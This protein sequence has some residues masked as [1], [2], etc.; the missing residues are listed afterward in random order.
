MVCPH[1][2]AQVVD[3]AKFCSQCGGKLAL[4]CSGCQALVQPG[5]KFCDQCGTAQ[6]T[7]KTP[8]EA[9]RPR[10]PT[11]ALKR[12]TTASLQKPAGDRRVVTVLFTDVSGFTAM[13]EKLDPEEV[14]EIVNNFFNVLV[15]PIY[16]YGGVVDKYIGDAIMA[17]FGAP[18]AHEDDPE[19]AVLAAWE[20]QHAAQRHAA[21]LEARTGI[22]LKVRIGLNT[23]LVVA[24]AVGGTQRSD[25]TVM[26]DTVNLAQRME[27]NAKPG[28]VLV[29]AETWNLSRHAFD[30]TALAP[31]MV[32]G[33]AE[34]VA[35]YELAGTRTLTATLT[36]DV[37]VIGRELEFEHLDRVWSMVQRGRPQWINIVGEMGLGK[38]ALARKFLMGLKSQSNAQ[39]VWGRSLSYDRQ[40]YQVVAHLLHHLL[41]LSQ[42]APAAEI[43]D[44]LDAL[45]RDHRLEDPARIVALLA[46]L[47]ALA[48]P[49]AEVDSL[50]PKHKRSA[51]FVA[52]DGVLSA[53][54]ARGPLVLSLEDLHW[55]DEASLEWIAHLADFLGE[56]PVPILVVCQTRPDAPFL[57]LA[58]NDGIDRSRIA[59]RPLSAE[60]SMALAS[61]LLGATTGGLAAAV[62]G[63]LDQVHWRAEGNPYYLTELVR[64][65]QDSGILV[66][67]GASWALERT[68]G[69]L[70][71]P[72]NVQ[73]AIAARLDRLDPEPRHLLQVAA[74]LGRS[75]EP[76]LLAAVLEA[77]P[78]VG[79]D[80]LLRAGFLYKRSTGE[81]GFS[82]AIIQEVAYQNLL[83]ATR[84]ELHQRVGTVLEMSS[85]EDPGSLARTLAFHFVRGEVADKACHYL[86]ASADRLRASYAVSEALAA[87]RQAL[88]WYHR[89]EGAADVDQASLLAGLAS[90]EIMTGDLNPALE[91][92]EAALA[93][94]P[95]AA[96]QTECHRLILKTLIRKG[97]DRLAL[98][99]CTARLGELEATLQRAALGEEER[100]E[101]A[102]LLTTR[103]EIEQRLGEFEAASAS[104]RQALELLEGTER[105]EEMAGAYNILGT[106]AFLRRN[107]AEAIEHYQRT[108]SLREKIKDA[109]GLAG[110][111]NN[112][113]L[114]Y[115]GQGQW[116]VA[117]EAYD[118]ALKMYSR[119]G[120]I[121]MVATLQT[122]LGALLLS[123]GEVERA[124]Q[125][126]RIGGDIYARLGNPLGQASIASLL[127]QA[128]IATGRP[129]QAVTQL[130][131]SFAL[132]E[133]VGA[134][135]YAAEVLR[136]LG[137]AEILSG[138]LAAARRNLDQGL[139][140]AREADNPQEIAIIGTLLA[141]LRGLEGDPA[142]AAQEVEVALAEL[143]GFGDPLELGRA[144]LRAARIFR[145][146]D[147][148][149]RASEV[150][151]EAAAI[152]SR[153]GATLD[154]ATA[155]ALTGV[156]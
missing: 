120:D 85:P 124:E 15:E 97:D 94:V 106:G 118:K 127:G 27:A 6:A 50:P 45:V 143:R 69:E 116:T 142:G 132:L 105:I 52:L 149:R 33:K 43:R 96:I 113:A 114:A 48:A 154:L 102:V 44:G 54:A 31:I 70:R 110:A 144:L 34:P 30:F 99:R 3:T 1:C 129:E 137:H 109:P 64:S 82:Q 20:M 21:E 42:Q 91:H 73:G 121:A 19:R 84:R 148:A 18:V 58:L 51:A 11:G 49:H 40:P 93:L 23:G 119:I 125:A 32:K 95:A 74:V 98:V 59:L 7:A 76:G 151:D 67:Q 26:G 25:Y 47:L 39:V 155:R 36:E 138:H 87:Y 38:S 135:V 89:A 65:L 66:R 146:D 71:L 16:R 156:G 141:E 139:A 122:N 131:R 2:S 5:Q 136:S 61:A 90:V 9:E 80:Q 35:V 123:M 79:L 53:L 28:K 92:L 14:T 107:F 145:A 83:M 78:Q 60:A 29:T 134:R 112:L 46:H 128:A 115:A 55:A 103:A 126:F 153:L 72:T 75:F 4:V 24:G 130:S 108:V 104:C 147:R 111:L 81:M 22:G 86:F 41:G 152:F 68:A 140:L 88:E 56:S 100:G 17:L 63:L 12:S 117:A 101:R 150:T 8:T 57:Q 13:S 62:Q 10:S 77:D 37:L 133:Q